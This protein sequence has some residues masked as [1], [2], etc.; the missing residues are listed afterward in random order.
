MRRGADALHPPILRLT[1]PDNEPWD[2]ELGKLQSI[3][4]RYHWKGFKHTAAPFDYTTYMDCSFS[5]FQ[6]AIGSIRKLYH[7]YLTDEECE[8]IAGKI[9]EKT[10]QEVQEKSAATD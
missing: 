1:T 6:Y 5:D 9:A 10:L 3:Q 4:F 2:I 8:Q 7:Q